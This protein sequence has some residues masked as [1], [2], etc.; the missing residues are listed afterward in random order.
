M[1]KSLLFLAFKDLLFSLKYFSR[2]IEF[3]G[4]Y[5]FYIFKI[6]LNFP[7]IYLRRQCSC[8]YGIH[9]VDVK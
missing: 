6:F 1:P 9:S 5:S 3:E 8:A 7:F 2:K 4:L